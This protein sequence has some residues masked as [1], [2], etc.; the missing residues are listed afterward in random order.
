M[1]GERITVFHFSDN[2]MLVRTLAHEL[3]HAIGIKH[4]S[5]PAS[6][7]Y[8]MHKSR[9]LELTPEE[10]SVMQAHYSIK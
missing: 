7:M 1:D 5:N 10:I 2:T 6:I 9:S 4:S 8:H 3:G